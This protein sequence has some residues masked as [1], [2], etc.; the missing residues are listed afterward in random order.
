[1]A[2]SLLALLATFAGVREARAQCTCP[3]E[4]TEVIGHRGT[5]GDRDDNPFPENTIASFLQAA[6]ATRSSQGVVG[7]YG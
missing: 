6:R 2:R 5:G 7:T 3:G 1:M 4:V